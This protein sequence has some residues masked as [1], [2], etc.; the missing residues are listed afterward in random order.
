M[1]TNDVEVKM[2][3]NAIAIA[4]VKEKVDNNLPDKPIMKASPIASWFYYA[5]GFLAIASWVIT[6][7]TQALATFDTILPDQ[8]KH[9][10]LAFAGIL[11]GAHMA[12]YMLCD[13]YD[14]GQINKSVK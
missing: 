6:G 1:T 11:T 5:T 10:V 12:V 13:W 7:I 3:D 8:W 4:E 9:I 2:Q 14:D